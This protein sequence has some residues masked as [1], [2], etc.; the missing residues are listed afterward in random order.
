MTPTVPQMAQMAAQQR[1]VQ[2]AQAK[3]RR[4]KLKQQ[5]PLHDGW[6]SNLSESVNRADENMKKDP[7]QAPAICVGMIRTM[8]EVYAAQLSEISATAKEELD[9]IEK[10]IVAAESP[11]SQVRMS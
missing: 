1:A 5:I 10:F 3:M 11:I 4:E 2:L 9:Q 6:V 8:L 7:S